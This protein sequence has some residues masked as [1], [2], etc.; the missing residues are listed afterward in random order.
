MAKT[1]SLRGGCFGYVNYYEGKTGRV[2]V[3]PWRER[4]MRGEPPIIV[5]SY[6]VTKDRRHRYTS[7]CQ[8]DGFYSWVN[9]LSGYSRK[10]EVTFEDLQWVAKYLNISGYFNRRMFEFFP[11]TTGDNLRPSLTTKAG[12]VVI[13]EHGSYA[14]AEAFVPRLET[15]GAGNICIQGD[16][17]LVFDFDV[18]QK[19]LPCGR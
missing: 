10:D 12:E 9:F 13:R 3:D 7:S 4:E 19:E 5:I 16:H 1:F 18:P 15:Y 6:G 17:C 11:S 2:E 14:N 8:T